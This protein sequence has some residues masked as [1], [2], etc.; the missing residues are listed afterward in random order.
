VPGLV[1]FAIPSETIY[2][3]HSDQHNDP[4]VARLLKIPGPHVGR[5]KKPGVIW[6]GRVKMI[7]MFYL[8]P[9]GC[10]ALLTVFAGFGGQLGLP[11]WAVITLVAVVGIALM[12]TLGWWTDDVRGNPT[13]RMICRHYRKVVVAEM[14]LRTDALFSPVD[15]RLIYVNL[16]PRQ[17]WSDLFEQRKGNDSGFLL[18]DT[19][20]Q[21]LLYE[22]DR[23]RF[24]IPAASILRCEVEDITKTQTT[25][26][27]YAAVI[28]ARTKTSTYTFPFAALEGIEGANRFEKAV[29][30][31]R[32]ILSEFETAITED[33]QDAAKMN[34]FEP[35]DPKAPIVF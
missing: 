21:Q 33:E 6:M 12:A 15:P 10:L 11:E 27:F 29:A 28:I 13:W 4:T 24:I 2:E 7:G 17:N 30:L 8:I 26:G 3:D 1:E 20:K 5:A 35:K 18:F 25:A 9:F 16:I 32:R 31:Q 22:G 23:Y 34:G 19:D 14:A